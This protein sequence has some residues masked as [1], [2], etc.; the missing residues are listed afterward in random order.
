MAW[1]KISSK[2]VF[3]HPRHKVFEDTVQL[4]NGS[5]TTYLHF[6]V[7]PDGTLII[8][9]NA[10]GKI[11]LQ[12]EYSY[13]LDEV[14]YQFPGGLME[15]GETPLQAASREF[16]EEAKL[17]GEL[18]AI[19]WFYPDN[20]RK[21]QKAHVFVA[22]GLVP[23]TAR[24]DAEESFEDFWFTPGEV[25]ELI[26]KNELSVY[27]ALAAW[28]FYKASKDQPFPLPDPSRTAPSS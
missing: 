8:A 9:I 14:I 23:A 6:G 24:M 19:G 15:K 3:E 7:V 13:P 20:R 4:P 1:K 28:A 5:E 22:T 26:R 12:K 2:K 25:D 27:S 11:L 21:N 10:E 18:Q 16:A 17:G